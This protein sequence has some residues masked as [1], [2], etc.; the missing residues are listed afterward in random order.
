MLWNKRCL[1]NSSN[2]ENS[3]VQRFNFCV[4][5]SE[6]ACIKEFTQDKRR[7]VIN[8][9]CKVWVRSGRLSRLPFVNSLTHVGPDAQRLPAP[10]EYEHYIRLLVRGRF[11]HRF[12]VRLPEPRHLSLTLLTN[13]TQRSKTSHSS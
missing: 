5:P 13:S 4:A 8:N 2:P 9:K 7:N 3:L 12:F 1:P 10:F 6:T 11:P